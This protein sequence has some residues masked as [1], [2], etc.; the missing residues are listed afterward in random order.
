MEFRKQNVISSTINFH[1]LQHRVPM[2][3]FNSLDNY[4]KETKRLMEEKRKLVDGL[5]N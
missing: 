4:L 3:F 5:D 1:M 2:T